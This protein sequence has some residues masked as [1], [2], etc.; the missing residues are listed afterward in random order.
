[1]SKTGVQRVDQDGRARKV[2]LLGMLSAVAV[3][4]SWLEGMLAPLPGM[5]PGAKLGL[6]NVATMLAA[7]TL[8][9]GSALTVTLIKGAFAGL[10]RGLTAGLMSLAGGLLSTGAVCLLLRWRR[11]PF[12]WIGIG[13][14]GAVC[15]NLGQLLVSYLLTN[16]A[17]LAYLPLLLLFALLAGAA[18]GLTLYILLPAVSRIWG[19]GG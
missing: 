10:T 17:V 8:G 9:P 14:T 11:C 7:T 1:M 12:G 4:L 16:A 2:A 6:S 18:T 13:V 3:A 5:P 15:H 19:K